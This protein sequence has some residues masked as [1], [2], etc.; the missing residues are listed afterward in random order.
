MRNDRSV[1]KN[2]IG[3]YSWLFYALAPFCTHEV[4]VRANEMDDR[5][6]TV[7]AGSYCFR[8]AY[9]AQRA[10]SLPGLRAR[11]TPI[12]RACG[13]DLSRARASLPRFTGN[14]VSAIDVRAGKASRPYFL[15]AGSIAPVLGIRSRL[16]ALVALQARISL[17]AIQAARTERGLG[18]RRE[19]LDSQ[20]DC[21]CN[22]PQ[23]MAHVPVPRQLVPRRTTETYCRLLIT[24]SILRSRRGP[25]ASA[26][27]RRLQIEKFV[28]EAPRNEMNLAIRTLDQDRF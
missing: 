17:G 4:V 20:S 12:K 13:F 11:G 5:I 21:Q 6:I 23:T 1:N 7:L 8:I 27:G 10:F 18:L 28:P 26:Y 24:L 14:A 19:S 15:E 9:L 16:S 25:G 22:Q 2:A 3:I